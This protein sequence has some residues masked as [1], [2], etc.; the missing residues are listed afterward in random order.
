MEQFNRAGDF[1]AGKNDPRYANLVGGLRLVAGE[2]ERLGEHQLP[3]DQI[4]PGFT[5]L[6]RAI[7]RPTERLVLPSPE[8]LVAYAREGVIRKF[9]RDFEIPTPPDALYEDIERFT[10]L[11]RPIR[12]IRISYQPAFRFDPQAELDPSHDPTLPIWQEGKGVN[13]DS[14]YWEWMRDGRLPV[15]PW[16]EGWVVSMG[17]TK[18]QYE[19]GGRQHYED[20]AFMEQD[21]MIALRNRT[22]AE[23]LGKNEYGSD[24]S[25]AR[26]SPDDIEGKII[27]YF[28]KLTGARGIIEMP[29]AL[30]ANIELNDED[31]RSGETNTSEWRADKLLIGKMVNSKFVEDTSRQPHRL[32]GGNSVDGGLAYVDDWLSDRRSGVIAFRLRG[33]Y[34]S[35]AA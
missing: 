35:Q 3:A 26:V 30:E 12:K 21:I 10:S 32:D 6:N 16:R 23:G 27:P 8:Q 1:Y 34:S 4:T 25:R 14:R 31:P 24:Y 5:A 17:G 22:D 7:L 15:E 33:R 9:G 2:A 11:E 19:D 18:P 28:V 13:L 29:T 20:D